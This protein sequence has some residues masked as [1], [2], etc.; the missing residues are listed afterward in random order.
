MVKGKSRRDQIRG[1]GP[2]DLNDSVLVAKIAQDDSE[3]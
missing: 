1:A 2:W 3:I